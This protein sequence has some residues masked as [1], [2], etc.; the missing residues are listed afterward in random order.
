[1]KYLVTGACGFIGSNFTDYILKKDK[2]CSVINIDKHTDVSNNFLELKY[3]DDPRYQE[4]IIHDLNNTDWMQSVENQGLPDIVLH[5]AAESHVDRSCENVLPFV[6]SNITA[7]MHVADFCIKHN[8]P[9]VYVSTDEV[10]GELG[11]DDA[12]FTE[13]SPID[14]R[15]PY[16]AT[17][18][19][20]GFLL[21]G[22]ANAS[23]Y[24]RFVITRCSNNFGHWQ[25][26]TKFIPVA[27]KSL[28]DGKRIPIYGEGMQVRDWIHVLD[29]CEAIRLV[30]KALVN[31][32]RIIPNEFNIGANNEWA[33]MDI[34]KKLC[35]IF[36][37]PYA[38][39]ITTIKDPRGGA[40][41]L[42]YAVDSS[43]FSKTF[44][45]SPEFSHPFDEAL[46]DTVDWYRKHSQWVF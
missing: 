43:R 41:D 8:L 25:D 11:M 28:M 22:L 23:D 2:K 4:S 24:N 15:N 20:A 1:M 31:T 19:G 42:R 5:F 26:S 34:A 39:G 12:P 18:A 3:Y 9:L 14:P 30:G 45:W 40:H 7:T 38:K 37:V 44:N 32:S 36:E 6:T 16:S 46:E 21:K 33:N 27:I 17:K 10:Y 13:H 35:N 29:H